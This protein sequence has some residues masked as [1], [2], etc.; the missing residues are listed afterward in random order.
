MYH[1]MTELDREKS[2]TIRLTEWEVRMRRQSSDTVN[3]VPSD[4]KTYG[5]DLLTLPH[6]A[7]RESSVSEGLAASR[8]AVRDTRVGG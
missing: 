8:T 7:W 6:V 4:L 3:L 2:I 5:R 1:V